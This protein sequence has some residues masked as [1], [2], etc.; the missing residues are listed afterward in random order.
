[1]SD[2]V[3]R[4]DC[5]LCKSK[6]IELIMHIASTP[7][8]FNFIGYD[9]LKKVQSEYPLELFFCYDCGLLQL[10][11]VVNREKVY[12]DYLYETSGSLGLPEHFN[13]YADEIL[14]RLD[15]K[16]QELIVDIGC[17]DGTL[18]SCFKNRGM[19]VLGIEPAHEI[20][21]KVDNSGIKTIAD[22][23]TSN[24]AGEI[25]K[26]HGTA[27]IITANN[28]FANIDDLDDMISGVRELLSPDG[29]FVFETGYML[30]LVQN[31]VLDNVYHEH[32]SYFSVK[33]LAKFFS[34]HG[35]RLVEIERVPTK[36]GSIRGTVQ[37]LSGS[38]KVSPSVSGLITLETELGFNSL[39]PFKAFV[40]RVDNVKNRLSEM[41][42]NIKADGQTVAGYGASVGVTTLLYYFNLGNMVE[43]LY[44]DNP[45]RYNL[46]SPGHHIPVFSSKEIYA[47]NPDYVIIFAWRYA[48]HI[49]TRHKKYLEQGGHFI[50]PLPVVEI[51]GG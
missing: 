29:I 6:N 11:G 2:Y 46:Y 23:F 3:K 20:A 21:D 35:L 39:T 31:T 1:M 47:Q 41:V 10:S 37:L 8:G 38:R 34:N 30:D 26:E 51:V 17:N 43:N 14:R 48:H 13:W 5:R 28:V 45:S 18:L 25:K 32:L 50:L 44:D 24:L 16:N 33:P 4:D 36:G 42:E 7:I 22:F 40:S 12:R 15:I 27:S 49:I 19:N 9:Q